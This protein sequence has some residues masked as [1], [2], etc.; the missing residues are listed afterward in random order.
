MRSRNRLLVW[1][2]L[3]LIAFQ[4]TGILRA[5]HVVVEHSPR[6]VQ[7]RGRSICGRR[8]CAPEQ[9]G[10]AL[11]GDQRA[12]V[13]AA[14][15]AGGGHGHQHD[16]STCR[17]CLALAALKALAGDLDPGTVLVLPPAPD[18][19]TPA[20]VVYSHLARTPVVPRAPPV[21]A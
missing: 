16:E 2:T 13:G 15:E 9:V 7:A 18:S 4:G 1:L 12:S 10:W 6:G 8:G 20:G 3:L 17:T 11:S 14:A 21:S 19:P 5:L